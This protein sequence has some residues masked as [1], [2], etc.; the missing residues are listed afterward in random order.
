MYLTM[1]NLNGFWVQGAPVWNADWQEMARTAAR[2]GYAGVDLPL[3]GAMKDGPEKV[4][5][6]LSELKLKPGFLGSRG[7]NPFVRDA[8][9]FEAALKGFDDICKFAAAIGAPRL[10][11]RMNSSMDV[12]KDQW[13]K[14]GLERA[15]AMS[16]VMDRH[17]V[18]M[19]IEFSGPMH[20]RKQFQ[21]EFIYRVPET[22]EFCKE[23]GPNWGLALDSWHWHHAG[24]TTADIIAAGKSRIAIVHLCDA[25]QQK[26]EEVKDLERVMPG[27]GVIDL[28]GFLKALKKIGY[29]GLVS[30]EPMRRFPASMSPDEVAKACLDSSVAVMKKAGVKIA[31][32]A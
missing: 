24:G 21:Y 26:P 18:F 8:A 14:V 30:P 2:A 12:P 9:A 17:N 31:Q 1:R 3:Q 20:Y 23:A 25:R 10:M 28:V 4:R 7:V 27:E 29:D 22:I 16:Q 32:R 11:F 6:V 15:K 13:R 5:A 19:G